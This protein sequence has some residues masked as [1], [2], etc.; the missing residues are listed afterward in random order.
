ML[1]CFLLK[2]FTNPDFLFGFESDFFR[3]ESVPNDDPLWFAIEAAAAATAPNKSY[4]ACDADFAGAT[5]GW[6]GDGVLF[7]EM[8]ERYSDENASPSILSS[9]TFSGLVGSLELEFSSWR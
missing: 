5:L 7:I 2:K 6:L 9:L 3:L 8:L 4:S 1:L